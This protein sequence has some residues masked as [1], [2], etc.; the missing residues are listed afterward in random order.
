ML[1]QRK[2]R[3]IV[4][5]MDPINRKQ[6]KNIAFYVS[7]NRLVGL[8]NGQDELHHTFEKH[9]ERDIKEAFSRIGRAL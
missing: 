4:P 7:F 1:K 2:Q 9:G 5:K 3:L 8:Y 6:P